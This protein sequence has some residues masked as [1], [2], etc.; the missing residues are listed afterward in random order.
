MVSRL[1]ERLPAAVTD[2][3]GALR[4]ASPRKDVDKP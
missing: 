4:R 1:A 3:G 2:T